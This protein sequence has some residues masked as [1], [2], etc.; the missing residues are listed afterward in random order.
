[1]RDYIVM[2]LAVS[3]YAVFSYGTKALML[4]GISVLTCLICRKIGNIIIRSNEP[5]ADFSSLATGITIAL[6]LPASAEWW[7]PVFAGIF[8]IGVCVI[9]FGSAAKAPFVPAAAAVCFLSVCWGDKMFS[10]PATG[11]SA[12]FGVTDSSPS[13][14]SMLMQSNSVGRNSAS[15]LEILTGNVPSAMGAGCSI[16]LIGALVYLLIRRP[17]GALPSVAFICSAALMAVI[18]PR[19][20]TGR[21][22]SLLMELCGGMLLFSAVFFMSYPSVL[23]ERLLP[24][25]LW[26]FA[27]GIICMCTRY[28]GTLDESVAFG[29]LIT[30]A[31]SEI[32]DKLPLTR[33]EKKKRYDDE[34]FIEI[35]RS[36]V[37][38]A[39]LS[40]IP[41]IPETAEAQPAEPEISAETESLDSV[42]SEENTI[43]ET[44]A[45]FLTGG[46]GNE[47]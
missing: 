19:V 46:D 32:F 21:A 25:I 43:T 28:L 42:I 40:E 47:Q 8:A 37:P 36:V 11:L 38:E 26:G 18:F 10:Y 34:P 22:A 45:P 44:A 7:M 35:P 13:L 41:D 9:P 12:Y 24:R 5:A 31:L 33:R 23:P 15:T 6:L 27:G 16:I 3:A 4:I 39:I 29:I 2:L 17:K 20:S 14:T 30:D 1:M